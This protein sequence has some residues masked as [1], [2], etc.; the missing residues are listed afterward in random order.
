MND[1][2]ADSAIARPATL[3]KLADAGS[4]KKTTRI[5][6]RNRQRILTAALSVFSTAGYR[7]ATIDRIAQAA[8]M[9]KPN[10]LYYFKTKQA[11]YIAV[12][13]LTLDSWLEPMTRLDASGDPIEEL[14]CYIEEKL[15]LSRQHPQAS[16]LFANEILHGAPNIEGYLKT[17]LKQLVEEKAGVI[18]HWMSAGKIADIDQVHLIF[19][20]WATTQHYADFDV[21]TEILAPG[22]RDERFDT[23]KSTLRTIFMLGI[24]P[25]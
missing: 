25:R 11:I 22:E 18:R 21:Q 17:S 24:K 12:L 14:W 16:K 4:H 7:G 19:M 2:T 15:E 1:V 6:E 20:I 5:Q 10:L 9:S 13:E 8:G 3:D 23:A